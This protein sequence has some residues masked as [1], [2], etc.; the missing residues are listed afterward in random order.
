MDILSSV[1][2]FFF[3]SKADKDRKEIE[4]YVLKI[5]EIEPSIQKLTNDELR[6]RTAALRR[7]I[8]EYIAADEEHIA[9]Q[10]AALEDHNISLSETESISKDIESCA[11]I[12]ALYEEFQ[13]GFQEMANEDW[14]TFRFDS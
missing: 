9:K 2:K 3:G 11:Q 1:I 12:W 10:K 8:A 14:I 4:P 5:K 6:A 13:Q 7:Q